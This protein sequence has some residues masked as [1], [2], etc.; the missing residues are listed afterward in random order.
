MAG[1]R[2]EEKERQGKLY[3]RLQLKCYHDRHDWHKGVGNKCLRNYSEYGVISTAPIVWWRSHRLTE[4]GVVSWVR[5]TAC[6]D[7]TWSAAEI[8]GSTRA[9]DCLFMGWHRICR[10]WLRWSVVL[11]HRAIQYTQGLSPKSLFIVILDVVG[12]YSL[13]RERIE[14]ASSYGAVVLR[15]CI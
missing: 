8:A 11:A 14:C 12:F 7:T 5:I 13:I 1:L 4:Y 6:F 3:F 2:S 15:I 10:F 9:E